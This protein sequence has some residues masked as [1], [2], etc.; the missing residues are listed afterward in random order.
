MKEEEKRKIFTEAMPD[1]KEF[2]AMGTFDHVQAKF[3][4]EAIHC[5]M[6]FYFS[7][8]DWLKARNIW[9][10]NLQRVGGK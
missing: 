1:P 10:P 2:F 8:E 3:Q 4:M 9:K 5:A 7:Q 6:M